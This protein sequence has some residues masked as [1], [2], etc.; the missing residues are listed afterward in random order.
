MP[1]LYCEKHGEEYE[2]AAR[3]KQDTYRQ[4]GDIVLV[5]KGRLLSGPCYLCAHCYTE[6]GKGQRACLIREFSHMV[7]REALEQYDFTYE[8][9]YFAAPHAEAASYGARWP[10]GDVAGQIRR[11]G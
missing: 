2:A 5:V 7:N 10:G 11:A 8:R 4:L 6:L 9:Y 1:Y 3:A